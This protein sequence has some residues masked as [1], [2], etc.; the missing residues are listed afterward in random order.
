[1]IMNL[2]QKKI[3]MDLVQNVSSQSNIGNTTI[4]HIV[5]IFDVR[6]LLFIFFFFGGGGGNNYFVK[7][8]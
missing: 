4:T 2:K 8:S 5:L 1:M 6:F 3:K 7:S